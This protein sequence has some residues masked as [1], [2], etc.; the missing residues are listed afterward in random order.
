MGAP[1]LELDLHGLTADMAQLEI[2]RFLRN[3][4]DKTTYQ[5]RLSHGYRSGT[6]LRSM[7]QQKYR[8]HPK[9]K[10]VIPGDN[11]GVTILVIRDL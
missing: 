5:V 7:I 3:K 9:V 6:A 8:S 4:V 10:R 11:P 2:D 1:F